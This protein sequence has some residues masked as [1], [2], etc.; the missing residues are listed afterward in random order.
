M[1]RVADLTGYNDCLYR[2]KPIGWAKK[3]NL[4]VVV[5]LFIANRRS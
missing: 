4:F 5:T 3:I 2:P 1:Q